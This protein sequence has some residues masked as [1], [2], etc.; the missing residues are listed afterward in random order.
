MSKISK[1]AAGL[2]ILLVALSAFAQNNNAPTEN[3]PQAGQQ[4]LPTID[5]VMDKATRA[6]GGRENLD[7]IK[8]LRSLMAMEVMGAKISIESLWSRKGG[9][10]SKTESDF[11]NIEMGSD[12]KNA[13]MVMPGAGYSLLQGDEANQV[14]GQASIIM[15][16]LDPKVSRERMDR[17][18]V[19]GREEFKGR[20]CIKVYFEPKDSEGHGHMFYD[21]ADGLPKGV[22]QTENS[23]MGQQTSTIELSDWKTIEGVL[24]FHQLRIESPSMPGGALQMKI[25]EIEINKVQESA[26]ELPQAVKA[27][28]EDAAKKKAANEDEGN[29]GGAPEIKFEDLPE[30]LRNQTRTMLDQLKSQGKSR[31]DMMLPAFEQQLASM[32]EGSE[33]QVL[34]YVIQELRKVE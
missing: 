18:E 33:K 10:Y 26:F 3:R 23:P 21:E 8:T 16:M 7:N 34:K 19:V 32:A 17:I 4:G 6:V 2:A 22:R 1:L 9:R 11:G 24:F 5:E 27:L 15:G 20:Q 28:V 12:G 29:N 30:E 31:I 25:T 13:W 14:D